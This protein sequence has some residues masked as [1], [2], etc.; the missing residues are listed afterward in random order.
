[1]MF[2]RFKQKDINPLI[3][4]LIETIAL[5]IIVILFSIVVFVGS[6]IDQSRN[7]HEPLPTRGI[8]RLIPTMFL[9]ALL[10]YLEFQSALKASLYLLAQTVLVFSIIVMA[11]LAHDYF[12]HNSQYDVVF[13]FVRSINDVL[14]LIIRLPSDVYNELPTITLVPIEFVI[15]YQIANAMMKASYQV[16]RKYSKHWIKQPVSNDESAP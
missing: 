5:C 8:T 16:W 11:Y 12:E 6:D 9:Y 15:F 4:V 3:M 1:M 13:I 10:R 14:E 2:R 7:A